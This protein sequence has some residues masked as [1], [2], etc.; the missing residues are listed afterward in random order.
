MT[1]SRKVLITTAITLAVV[2]GLVSLLAWYAYNHPN[3]PGGPTVPTPSQ[4]G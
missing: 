4:S 2:W 1:V 3:H